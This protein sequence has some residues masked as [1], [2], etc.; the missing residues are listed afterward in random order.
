MTDPV[1]EFFARPVEPIPPEDGTFAVIAARARRRRMRTVTALATVALVVGGLATGTVL[2][3]GNPLEDR[4]TPA[5]QRSP[6]RATPSPSAPASPL[7]SR[8]PSPPTASPV[9]LA[10]GG[11]AGALGLPAGGPIPAGFRIV[12]TTTTTHDLTYLLGTAPCGSPPCTSV[13]RKDGL[14]WHGIPA[15]PVDVASAGRPEGPETVRDVRFGTPRDGWAYGGALWSTHDGGARWHA[16]DVGGN[17][18][19][20]ASDGTT[21]YAVVSSCGDGTGACTL[22]LRSTPVGRDAW[23]DVTGVEESGSTG[24]VSVGSG[25][26]AASF[27]SGTVYVRSRGGVWAPARDLCGGTA[28]TVVASASSVRVFALCGDAAAGS[29]YFDVKF[30]DD[31]GGSWTTV[32]R[33]SEGLQLSGGPFVSVTAAS[34]TVLVA[35]SGS[36]DLGGRVMVSRDAGQSWQPAGGG[37]PDR[38]GAAGGGWR[39]VG[40]SSRDRILALAADPNE[41]YWVSHDAGLS[42]GPVVPH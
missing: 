39:Y 23:H 21:V 15:P 42:W 13:L 11:T 26:A 14:R 3:A 34:S 24:H 19:D 10:T 35:A 40:A 37:M 2:F 9:P 7:A 4:L 8:V 38:S 12:S 25:T 6:D 16:V 22:R 18:T 31:R 20:L 33:G 30:T 29:L 1:R 32:T 41:S 27:D 17:V 36:P 5:G 28:P